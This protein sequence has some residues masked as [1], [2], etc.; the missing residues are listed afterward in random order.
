MK[1]P[2]PQ[3]T[4]TKLVDPKD[5]ML[6]HSSLLV[7]KSFRGIFLA[8]SAAGLLALSVQ[9]MPPALAQSTSA[10]P[11]PGQCI[12]AGRLDGDAQWAPRFKNLELLD[13]DGKIIQPRVATQQSAKELLATV[14]Q[15]RI[16]APALLSSCNGN[17]AIPKGDGQA[18]Q[19]HTEAPAVSAGKT[20][21]AVEAISY[22]PLGLGGEWVE[23]K[24]A[25]NQERVTMVSSRR[26]KP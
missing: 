5:A 2:H 20:L 23:L 4:N 15:V 3:S 26:S 18:S 14:K 21:I 22:P 10:S 17:Q 25:L 9:S 11:Q 13:I 19:A 12:L 24:L 6:R 7:S 16:N 1:T 8:S